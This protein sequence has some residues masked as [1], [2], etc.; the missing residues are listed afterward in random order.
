MVDNVGGEVEEFNGLFGGS[1]DEDFNMTEK[2]VKARKSRKE[3]G[4]Q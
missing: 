4:K 3:K 2:T 1:F